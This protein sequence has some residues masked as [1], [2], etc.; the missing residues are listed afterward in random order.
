MHFPSRNCS[1]TRHSISRSTPGH[2]NACVREDT[3]VIA[4]AQTNVPLPRILFRSQERRKKSRGGISGGWVGGSVCA[5]KRQ[6]QSQQPCVCLQAVRHSPWRQVDLIIVM[7]PTYRNGTGFSCW[8]WAFLFSS[9]EYCSTHC[10]SRAMPVPI[11]F[12]R[13]NYCP[14]IEKIDIG[15][16]H[17]NVF[18]L[19]YLFI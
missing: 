4:R 13:V 15:R 16:F 1:G 6:F 2:L 12:Q 19:I 9:S 7:H 10:S 8:C 17:S 18:Y 5:Y 14:S 11:C 3:G